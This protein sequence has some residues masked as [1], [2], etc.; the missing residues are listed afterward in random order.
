MIRFEYMKLPF[1]IIP[2]EIIAPYNL[3][4]E[5][6]VYIEIRQGIPG[7]KQA[8][9]IANDRLIRHLA[10]F[11]YTLSTKTPTLW[12][13]STRN[14]SFFLVD[15]DFRVNYVGKNNTDDLISGLRELY[16]FSTN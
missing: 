5:G 12:R 8:G 2:D 3:K 9:L 10:K 11:G 4:D 1:A 13:H 15:D 16:T 7:L 6:W 14:I